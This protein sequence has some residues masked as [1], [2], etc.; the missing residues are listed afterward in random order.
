[1]CDQCLCA[2]V[3]VERNRFDIFLNRAADLTL[4]APGVDPCNIADDRGEE[5]VDG[6]EAGLVFLSDFGWNG[7]VDGA[8]SLEGK[9]TMLEAGQSP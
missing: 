1:M 6:V 7:L 5:L 2:Q 3:V 8:D 9:N 4:I